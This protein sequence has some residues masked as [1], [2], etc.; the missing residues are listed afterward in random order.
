MD[1]PAAPAVVHLVTA[2]DFGGVE[3]HV[4]LI[5]RAPPI[6]YAH[7]FCALGGGGT[8]ADRMRGRGANVDLLERDPAVLNLGTT[9][10]LLR[11]LRRVRPVVIHCHGTEANYHG[12][13]AGALARVPVRIGEEIGI[14]AHSR[15]A[16]AVF[17][18]VYR[19]A[20]KVIAVSD[21]VADWL[22]AARE[23][24]R[25]QIVCLF[26]P[27]ELPPELPMDP[28]AGQFAVGYVGRM[29]WEKNLPALLRAFAA[30]VRRG[31]PIRLTIIGD[32]EDRPL[33]EGIVREEGLDR[34][35]HL[36]GFQSDPHAG[37]RKCHLYAQPSLREGFSLALV[38]AMGCGLPVLATRAGAAA[39][40]VDHGATGWLIGDDAKSI[41]EGLVTAWEAG[42]DKLAEMG[43]RARASVLARFEVQD[44]VERLESIYRA[45]RSGA[46]AS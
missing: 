24:R 40:L 17:R 20:H 5:S 13:L 41:E 10:A 29:V 32:G 2:L 45:A 38:E 6:G 23:A 11:Y 28:P 7:R 21:V 26:S 4:E 15:K 39:Q 33:L 35:V 9:L 43:R 18:G 12:L 3:R 34:H 30:V 27:V 16:Q 42:P 22:V 1:D 25:D 37:L 46:S 31:I 8:T 14:P 36:A 19:L 44:Y